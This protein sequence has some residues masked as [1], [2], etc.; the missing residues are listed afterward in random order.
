LSAERI[1][2]S[3]PV[4]PFALLNLATIDLLEGRAD[5]A[6]SVLERAS[7]PSVI[8]IGVLAYAYGVAGRR[9]D[10]ERQIAT[11]K[12]TVTSESAPAYQIAMG[13]AGLGDTTQA[14]DWLERAYRDRSVWMAWLR[15]EPWFDKMRGERRFEALMT[16]LKF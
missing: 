8:R 3:E 4:S 1:I 12:S 13:Y 9:A 15:V 2:A 14:I 5:A 6:V 10:A 7:A 11:L 16:K